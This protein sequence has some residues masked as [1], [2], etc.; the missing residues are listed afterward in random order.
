MLSAP[1]SWKS[2]HIMMMEFLFLSYFPKAC[3]M[4]AWV[5][6]WQS[7]DTAR[8]TSQQKEKKNRFT[9]AGI[10]TDVITQKKQTAP[11]HNE[12]EHKYFFIRTS[13]FWHLT[14][15]HYLST[16][17]L[18]SVFKA[19]YFLFIGCWIQVFLESNKWFLKVR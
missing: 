12:K 7:V 10:L 9:G 4:Y 11:F 17:S 5:Q 6:E 18:F 16:N 1:E 14:T 15:F 13:D 8:I 2:T 19:R 3:T